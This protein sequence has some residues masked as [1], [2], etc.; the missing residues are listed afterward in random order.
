[1]VLEVNYYINFKPL[2]EKII[3]AMTEKSYEENVEKEA[4]PKVSEIEVYLNCIIRF[5][6]QN[7]LTITNT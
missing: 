6:E 1:M 7:Y 4:K 5:T 3:I 2:T